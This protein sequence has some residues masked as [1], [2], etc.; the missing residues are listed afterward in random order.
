MFQWLR[1]FAEAEVD[2]R[3]G[4]QYDVASHSA[5][6]VQMLAEQRERKSYVKR[7]QPNTNPPYI[8][9][10]FRECFSKT[11]QQFL[12]KITRGYFFPVHVSGGDDELNAP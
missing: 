4:V 11:I 3:G 7:A 8:A 9:L 10:Q 12:V 1:V 2:G 6:P 5:N